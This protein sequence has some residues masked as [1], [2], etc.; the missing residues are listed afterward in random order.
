MMTSRAIRPTGRRQRAAPRARM[1]PA[2]TLVELM[3]SLGI[4][5]VI[6][7]AAAGSVALISRA[8]AH[9]D[10][11]WQ[12]ESA[13]YNAIA[14]LAADLRTAISVAE[15]S[16]HA[17][18]F[19]VPDRDGD[20]LDDSVR[21]EFSGNAGDPLTYRFKQQPTA[22]LVASVQSFNLAYQTITPGTAAGSTPVATL[23]SQDAAKGGTLRDYAIDSAHACAQYFLPTFPAGTTSW[24]VKRV[25]IM[26]RT[27]GANADGVIKV[28]LTGA[29]SSMKPTSTVIDEATLAETSLDASD[30]WV[31][32]TYSAATGLD[33]TKG[34][35]VVIVR[36]AGTGAAG[37]ACYQ[38]GATTTTPGTWWTTSSNG[39]TTW[40]A[41]TQAQ[42]L[43]FYV[44]GTY[45]TFTTTSRQVLTGVNISFQAG[46]T[47][48]TSNVSSVGLMDAPEIGP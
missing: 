34:L 23:M 27:D 48:A 29:D 36:S 45:D 46:P 9:S 42:N 17:I 26:A 32:L 40:A 39:G 43:Q 7:T 30:S 6:I 11:V 41:P 1:R 12:T 16:P 44:Y 28:R 47:A 2:F 37:L 19:T 8:K 33:P 3:V 38:D 18:E 4:Y 25:R 24:N 35:C 10:G 20:G 31:D 5:G 15:H 22:T 14:Q 21:Y 13:G